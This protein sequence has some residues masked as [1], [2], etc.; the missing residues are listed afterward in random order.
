VASGDPVPWSYIAQRIATVELVA[1]S[2][3]FT[4][5]EVQIATLTAFLT[6][7]QRYKLMY[8]GYVNSTVAADS[9]SIRL[10]ED[11]LTGTQFVQYTLP[12]PNAGG[13]GVLVILYGEYVAVAS[14][15]KTFVVGGIR[16]SGTGTGAAQAGTARKSYFT[17]DLIPT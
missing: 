8:V 9:V 17:L 11:S 7:G 15:N 12:L 16:T 10:R 4:T 5:A 3:G 2:A 14:G 13:T 1:N 6:V